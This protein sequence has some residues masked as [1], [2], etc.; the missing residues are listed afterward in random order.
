MIFLSTVTW[1][2]A[3]QFILGIFL[4]LVIYKS[5]VRKQD[6]SINT[7]FVSFYQAFHKSDALL[8]YFGFLLLYFGRIHCNWI[9]VFC[10]DNN[11]L[12]IFW[13]QYWYTICW[14]VLIGALA[15][16]KGYKVGIFVFSL[17]FCSGLLFDICVASTSCAP[18]DPYTP[19]LGLVQCVCGM[20]IEVSIFFL[21]FLLC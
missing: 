18:I 14:T 19:I 12:N 6:V 17:I 13:R 16:M 11:Q 7:R 10:C 21:I 15:S 5:V 2:E 8:G 4:S 1:V 20:S 3:A 9:A